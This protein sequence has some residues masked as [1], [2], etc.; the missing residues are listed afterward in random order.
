MRYI[1]CVLS[2]VAFIALT[3]APAQAQDEARIKLAHELLEK[4]GTRQ[5]IDTAFDQMLKMQQEMVGKAAAMSGAPSD[6]SKTTEPMMKEMSDL[7]KREMS[8]DVMAPEMARIYAAA[9]T[10]EEL[11]S[12]IAFFD[13]PAGKAFAAKMP[14]LQTKAMMVSQARAMTLMPKIQEIMKKY[15][16]K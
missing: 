5:M 11:K 3:A 13:S 14:E 2:L 15:M 1:T 7:M 16:P 6:A 10:I 9:F 12:V 8:F 4:M